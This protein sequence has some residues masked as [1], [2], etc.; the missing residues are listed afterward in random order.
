M[1][2]VILEEIGLLVRA[3]VLSFPLFVLL[4]VWPEVTIWARFVIIGEAELLEWEN[5]VQ[6]GA[7]DR[8]S[9]ADKES[10]GHELHLTSFLIF[11]N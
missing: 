7:L 9:S 5:V 6:V 11:I 3:H 1:I 4:A 2:V 8:H 10:S